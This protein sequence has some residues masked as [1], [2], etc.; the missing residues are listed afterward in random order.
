MA[1]MLNLPVGTSIL[2]AVLAA[3]LSESGEQK[4][5]E[6]AR[7]CGQ[8]TLGRKENID[9]RVR[10]LPVREKDTETARPDVGCCVPLRANDYAM[11]GKCPG[12][13]A[14]AVIGAHLATDLDCLLL[15]T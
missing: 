15:C 6:R 14:F 1:T 7:L 11:T 13:R 4:V 10:Q 3:I 8:M 5:D 12:E 2:A 9:I